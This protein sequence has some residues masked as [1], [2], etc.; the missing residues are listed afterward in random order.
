MMLTR[1]AF[2]VLL[3]GVLAAPPTSEPQPARKVP[4]IG[5]LHPGASSTNNLSLNALRQG[6]RELGY[7]EGRDINI[8][9]RYAEGK[10]ERFAE[11]ATELVRLGADVLVVPAPMI[12][13]TAK[14]TDRIPIVM[15]GAADPVAEGF[16]SSLAR[17][18]KNVTGLSLSSRDL[19][20]KRVQL[21]KEAVPNVTRVGLLQVPGI[22]QSHIEEIKAATRALG[23]Q[24]E[25]LEAR[26][27]DEYD[28]AF[29]TAVKARVGALL[30]FSGAFGA[31][32]LRRVVEL[33]AKHR[34][35]TLYPV[36]AFVD[37]GGLMSYGSN[38]VERWHHAATY[39]DKILKGAKPA[40][41]P[42]EQPTKFELVI[43]LKTAKAL[44][45][46][47]PPSMLLRADRVIE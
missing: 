19:D 30:V 43:N 2:A 4:T 21:L 11:L 31:Q 18:G 29:E 45:L 15:A 47:I 3:L 25:L 40:D 1:A 20:G 14:A 35:P 41:L 22:M 7:A 27:P 24:L 26:A 37:A 44:G 8:A 16:V 6:L 9:S 42:I 28:R 33:A 12:A 39:V 38:L 13:A 36:G 10:A 23:L 32:Y 17:P 5:T 34:V 46:T